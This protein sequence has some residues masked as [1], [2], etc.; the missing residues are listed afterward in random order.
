MNKKLSAQDAYHE[1]FIHQVC[2]DEPAL[3]L[4]LETLAEKFAMQSPEGLAAQKAMLNPLDESLQMKLDKE[5]D[6][7]VAI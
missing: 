5:L 2:A 1:S 6:E 4:Y 3:D 7:F